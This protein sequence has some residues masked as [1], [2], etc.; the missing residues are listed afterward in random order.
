MQADEALGRLDLRLGQ[1]RVGRLDQPLLGRATVAL[2]IEV[3]LHAAEGVLAEGQD[4]LRGL[5]DVAGVL[6]IGRSSDDVEC[7]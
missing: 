1:D 6:G 3:A 4:R 5:G 2:T 7:H